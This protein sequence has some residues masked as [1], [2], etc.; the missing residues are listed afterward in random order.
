[1]NRLRSH[2]IRKFEDD[3][4]YRM[5][6]YTPKNTQSVEIH[7]RGE[8]T[9]K[10]VG[11]LAAEKPAEGKTLSGVLVRRNFKLHMMAPEDLQR[12]SENILGREELQSI[13]FLPLDY[14]TLTRSTVTQRLGIP[15]TAAAKL[16]I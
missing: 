3:P 1:M 9:V 5:T 15:F 10:V 7:F 16:F 4:E 13:C 2:L 11:Q 12:I 8:K 14:T 6:V